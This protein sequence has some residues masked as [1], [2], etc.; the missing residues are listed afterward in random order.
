MKL[1][2]VASIGTILGTIMGLYL[3]SIALFILLYICMIFLFCLFMKRKIVPF[4]PLFI[5]IIIFYT[6]VTLLENQYKQMWS[7]YGGEEVKIEAIVISNPKEKEY[8]NIYEIKVIKIEKLNDDTQNN[9]TKLD[10]IQSNE[11]RIKKIQNNKVESN[12]INKSF[13]ILCNIKKTK[14]ERDLL[15][16]GD[17]ISFY[18]TFEKPSTARNQGGFDYRQYLKTKQIEGIVNIKSSDINILETKQGNPIARKI[19]NFKKYLIE[20]I[21]KIL[22]KET[23]GICIGL[24]LGEK[25]WITEEVQNAF[26]KSSLSHMLAISGAHVSYI[27]TGILGL[28]ERLR[29]HK[30]WSKLLVILFLVFYMFLVGFTPSVIRA[31]IMAILTLLADILFQKADVYQNLAISSF[32]IL[33]INPYAILDIGF[34]LSFGGTMG[35]VLFMNIDLKQKNKLKENR[36]KKINEYENT[37]H[38]IINYINQ[39]IIVSISANLIIL[40]IM[41]YHFN[42]LSATF[43]ISNILASPILGLSLILGMIFILLLLVCQPIAQLFSFL[44]NPILKLLIQIA[45][46][47]GE[48]PFSQILLPTPKRCQVIIYYFIL[49]L[50]FYTKFKKQENKED[51]QLINTK[52][53][54]K[55]ISIYF[56][57][58]FYKYKRTIFI[59]TIFL[60]ILPYTLN[61]IP[62]N[63]LIIRLID[64]GQGDSMLIKTPSKKTILIDGGGSESGS[65]DIGEQTLLPY[66][67]DNNIL[68]IDYMIFSHFDTDHCGGLFTILEK[69]KVKNVIISKQG[70]IS[71]NFNK[72]LELIQ[73]KKVNVIIVKAGDKVIIDKQCYFDILFPTENLISENVLNNNSIVAKFYL[74]NYF[75]I[76]LTGDI[77]QIAEEKIVEKYKHT[78]MLQ[79]TIL[80]VAHHGSK[81]SS[82]EDFLELVKPKIAL[83]GVGEKNTF[84]HPNQEV[85]DRLKTCG[86]KIYRTDLDG[87]IVIKVKK[88]EL[89]IRKAIN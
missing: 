56:T 61:L 71:D 18:A 26:R 28:L 20:E 53:L 49:V 83:I 11:N 87:E 29:F 63:H 84:G 23:V 82:T 73:N 35:I 9:Q 14:E 8:K 44:L 24:L 5:C 80:K 31:C 88:N 68:R 19:N 25:N 43:L 79:A 47:S 39:M 72:F 6:Y 69:C 7:R 46:F 27:L 58:V 33:L 78:N 81:S 42:T 32:I 76:L 60:L 74:Q 36:N 10:Q 4:L 86:A 30:R 77:E 13:K 37:K 75:S 65:F 48:I 57:S 15:N 89:K 55:R 17:K 66:L 38:K 16:Y 34:Q 3:K 51:I 64:V 45:H 59:I 1:F 21:S 40:P 85:L 54:R 41:L 70:E 62:T 67:L 22:P 12:Q 52:N 50:F 2:C